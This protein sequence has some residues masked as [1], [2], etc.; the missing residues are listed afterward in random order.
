MSFKGGIAEAAKLLA[1]L[2]RQGRENVLAIIAEKS[3]HMA[4]ILKKHMVTMD[5]LQHLTTKMLA[6]L[7]REIKV[8]DLGLSLRIASDTNSMSNLNDNV[9][10]S[11]TKLRS[12]SST[13][14]S[15]HNKLLKVQKIGT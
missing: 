1:G 14:R 9:K 7:L 3:P 4:D 12:S 11:D 15:D 6:E 8:S 13:R 10:Q 2:D 5:D